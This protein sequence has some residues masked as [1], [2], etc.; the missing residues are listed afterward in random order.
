MKRSY[1]YYRQ[2]KHLIILEDQVRCKV[3]LS[4]RINSLIYAL[5]F[6]HIVPT[7]SCCE[8]SIA[9]NPPN[10]NAFPSTTAKNH[11]L[12]MK[13]EPKKNDPNNGQRLHSW[14][15]IRI[16]N[17]ISEQ[18]CFMRASFF[19]PKSNH[20]EQGALHTWP[21]STMERKNYHIWAY[22]SFIRHKGREIVFSL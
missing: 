2:N 18:A 8:S 20:L 14:N 11:P 12:V 15:V 6:K 22:L 3:L 1:R 7:W 5:I 16:S 4:W 19:L 10:I 21:N 9:F 13:Y 17:Q